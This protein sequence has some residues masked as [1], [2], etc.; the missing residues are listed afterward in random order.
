MRELADTPL[1]DSHAVPVTEGTATRSGLSVRVNLSGAERGERERAVAELRAASRPRQH[2]LVRGGGRAALATIAIAI[3]V[4]GLAVVTGLVAPG[5]WIGRSLW[6]ARRRREAADFI[7]PTERSLDNEIERTVERLA[8]TA[9]L[10]ERGMADAEEAHRDL[11][12]L[13]P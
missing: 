5:T 6:S 11:L 4:P 12:A 1:T 7:T 8:D 2:R 3:A 9:R 13:L 10:A